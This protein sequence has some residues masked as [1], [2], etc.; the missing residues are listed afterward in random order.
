MFGKKRTGSTVTDSYVLEMVRAILGEDVGKGPVLFTQTRIKYEKPYVP[1]TESWIRKYHPY[2]ASACEAVFE[3]YFTT[4][5]LPSDVRPSVKVELTLIH[6][7]GWGLWEVTRAFVWVE[8]IFERSL[9]RHDF[10]FTG[11][12]VAE[13]EASPELVS[14]SKELTQRARIGSQGVIEA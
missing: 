7:G 5:Q 2:V 9:Q 8:G 6:E 12:H 1:E 4:L 14:L 11:R 13:W 10:H 3:G